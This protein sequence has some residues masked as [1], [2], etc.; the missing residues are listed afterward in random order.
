MLGIILTKPRVTHKLNIFLFFFQNLYVMSHT[1]VP[2]DFHSRKQFSCP[3]E[4]SL[5]RSLLQRVIQFRDVLLVQTLP[6]N[7]ILVFVH[8]LLPK[9]SPYTCSPYHPPFSFI[10]QIHFNPIGLTPAGLFTNSNVLFLVIVPSW[11]PYLQ[12]ILLCVR[13]QDSSLARHPP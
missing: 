2:L 9:V 13:L 3:N 10:L 4:K 8:S 12:P 5:I 7:I 11:L 1:L 6:R